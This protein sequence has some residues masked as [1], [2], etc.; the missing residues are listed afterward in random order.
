M[1]GRFGLAIVALAGLFASPAFAQ[2]TYPTPAGSRVNGTVPLV[3]DAT[4][5]NCIPSGS[6]GSGSGTTSDP[7]AVQ[8]NVASVTTDVGNPV[9]VGG[10]YYATNPFPSNGQRVDLSVGARGSLRTELYQPNGSNSAGFLSSG[11]DGINN[12]TP[13]Y[14]FYTRPA[15]FNG[16]TWD[17]MRGDTS[18]QY[19]VEV[20]SAAAAA[21]VTTVASTAVSGGLVI[22]ASP[23]NLY[24]F[25]VVSGA[26]AGFV[27]IFNSTTVPADGAVTPSRC[28]PLAANTGI[29]VNLRGQPTH[30]STGIAI[31]FSTTGCFSKTA[32]AT[33]FIAGDAQ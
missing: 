25:N 16:T 15:V 9:K 8:G 7:A 11:A 17:R 30:F 12:L 33:A 23:G 22:K 10:V 1:M 4:G 27:L 28:I 14:V 31:V 24:G 20:P 21:G 18:G 19:V 6:T 3:C 26:S 2:T 13:S 29:D 32:S 5:A